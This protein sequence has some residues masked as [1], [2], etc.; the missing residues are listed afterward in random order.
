MSESVREEVLVHQQAQGRSLR[1][2]L[3]AAALVAV[4]VLLPLRSSPAFAQACAQTLPS[5]MVTFCPDAPALASQVNANL[6]ALVTF[7]QQKVGTVGNANITTAG[8]LSSGQ[9]TVAGLTTAGSVTFGATTRQMVNLYNS[10]YGLGVQAATGYFRTGGG[11]AWF[12]GGFHNDA[13]NNSGGG[14]TQA[15]LNDNGF[16]VRSRRIPSEIV[17]ASCGAATCGA[18]CPSGTV[19]KQAFGIHGAGPT[20]A[21]TGDWNCGGAFSWMGTCVNGTSCTVITGCGNSGMYLECW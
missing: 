18:S 12:R 5:P 14:V 4:A 20:A 9:A 16:T 17:T 6:Q 21:N 15:T 11:F 2:T 13:T 8:T 3:V 19:I 1:R 7:L 10:E